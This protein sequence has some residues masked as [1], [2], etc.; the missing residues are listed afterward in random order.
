MRLPYD[1]GY[2]ILNRNLKDTVI[3]KNARYWQVYCH[4]YIKANHQGCKV[5]VWTGRNTIEVDLMRGQFVSGRHQ[6]AKAV[7]MPPS[8]FRNILNRFEGLRILDIKK[9]KHYS[10]VTMLNY[11]DSQNPDNYKGQPKGQALDRLRTGIGQAQDTDNNVKKVKKVKKEPKTLCAESIDCATILADGI[12][13]NDPGEPKLQPD[14]KEATVLKW[15]NDIDKINR[16]DGRSWQDIRNVAGW[17]QRDDFEKNNV[18]SGSKMRKRFSN[19]LGK[20][21]R[22][23]GQSDQDVIDWVNEGETIVTEGVF[24]D[25]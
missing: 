20:S 7:N 18:K 3:F 1:K 17:V 11:C 15:A 5:D 21:S 22:S 25:E 9:D 4:F 13:R 19:L 23:K 8:T 2:I 6:D 24:E 10:I 14:K 16:L 12:L